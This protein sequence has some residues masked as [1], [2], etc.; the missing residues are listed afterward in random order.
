MEI[1]FTDRELDVM[2][3]LWERG[4]ST[5]SEVRE[6]MS[7]DLAYTTVLTVMQRLVQQGHLEHVKEGP[8]RDNIPK[9]PTI[10]MRAN[11]SLVAH[12]GPMIRPRVSETFD[13]EAFIVG[14]VQHELGISLD[15]IQK[16]N[17]KGKVIVT[18]ETTTTFAAT[19]VSFLSPG[20]RR[21]KFCATC[22]S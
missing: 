4:P 7:D 18:F 2:G 22:T 15:D 20:A 11:S 9:F 3:V 12:E 10:F 14:K 17:V 19:A 5:V 21:S 13:Y 1:H 16:V 6:A 8:N